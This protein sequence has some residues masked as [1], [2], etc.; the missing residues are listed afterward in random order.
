MRK[1]SEVVA[2]MVEQDPGMDTPKVGTCFH[3]PVSGK[4]YEVVKP[5]SGGDPLPPGFAVVQETRTEDED[6]TG[7]TVTATWAE[8]QFQPVQFNSFRV[9]PFAASTQVR[10]GETIAQA[11]VRLHAELDV[12]AQQILRDKSAA[13]LR[14]LKGIAEQAGRTR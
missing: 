14:S 3:E 13:Y 4:N 1:R 7:T 2:A 11:T 6:A 12:A 5:A 8:E 9:G 10:A